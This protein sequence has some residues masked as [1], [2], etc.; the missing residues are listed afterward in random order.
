MNVDLLL[1]LP[2]MHSFKYNSD[3][4]SY[5]EVSNKRIIYVL[6]G[7]RHSLELSFYQKS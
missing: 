3:V 1:E 7:W 4:L 2:I 5:T 6:L